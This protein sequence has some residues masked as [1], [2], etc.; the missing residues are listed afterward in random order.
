MIIVGAGSYKS[1]LVGLV[2]G[3][4]VGVVVYAIQPDRWEAKA[5]VQVGHIVQGSPIEPLPIVIERLKSRAYIQKLAEQA[6]KIEV[7]ELLDVDRGAGLGLRPIKGT[8]SLVVTITGPTQ[9]L[10]R[11]SI[12]LLVSGLVSSHKVI[13]DDYLNDVHKELSRLDAAINT[14]PQQGDLGMK[15]TRASTLRE[16][17]FN[18]NHSLTHL[19]EPISVSETHILKSPIRSLLLFGLLGLVVV[20]IRAKWRS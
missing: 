5:L 11:I 6:G 12:N 13:A 15:I 1:Y 16:S 2:I 18:Y 17:I 8:D 10:V 14:V 3:M 9:E 4:L 7:A 20:A 19:L